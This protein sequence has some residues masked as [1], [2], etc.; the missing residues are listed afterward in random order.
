ME[1]HLTYFHLNLKGLPYH[2]TG[3]EASRMTL[4]YFCLSALDLLDDTD[5]LNGEQKNWTEW[6]YTQ[7]IVSKNNWA[8][9][10]G[11]PSLGDGSKEVS[12]SIF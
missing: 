8:G 3:S 10:R 5:P 7:Q 1:Q 4:I 12:L 11:G 9:F 6:I 2:Y